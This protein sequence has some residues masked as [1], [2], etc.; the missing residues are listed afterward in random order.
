MTEIYR[1]TRVVVWLGAGSKSVAVFDILDY[2]HEKLTIFDKNAD[3][4]VILGLDGTAQ[5]PLWEL[6]SRPWFRMV[7][8]IQEA[9]VARS[10]VVYC[11]KRAHL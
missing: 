6:L 9:M 8:I 3:K 2:V 10:A 4:S 1:D 11:G 5:E 7:W